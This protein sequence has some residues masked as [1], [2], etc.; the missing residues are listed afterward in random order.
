[1]RH[2]KYVVLALMTISLL[3]LVGCAPKGTMSNLM[4]E[5]GY[6]E[7]AKNPFNRDSM[8]NVESIQASANVDP[9]Y[10]W[11]KSITPNP[12][13]FENYAKKI[14]T[15]RI[16][17]KSYFSNLD[18]FNEVSKSIHPLVQKYLRDKNIVL[19]DG[20]GLYY[21]TLKSFAFDK[22]NITSNMRDVMGVV[23][24]DQKSKKIQP[25]LLVGYADEVGTNNYNI[26][27]SEARAKALKTEFEKIGLVTKNLTILAGGET[28]DYGPHQENRRGILV[29]IVKQ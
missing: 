29:A 1:M 13:D 18:E 25:I 6:A 26:V 20:E 11:Q 8:L 15:W 28:T 19:K 27:L 22:N 21:Y 2:L 23:L 14:V 10:A 4:K 9:N 7:Q 12:G 24:K 17:G 5:Q 3:V 16:E